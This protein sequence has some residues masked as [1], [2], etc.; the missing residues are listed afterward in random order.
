MKTRKIILFDGICNLCNQSVQFVIEHDDKNQFQFASLQS[1][2]GQNFLK[3]NNL[4]ATQFDSVVFIEDDK[5]YTKSSA[6]LKISKYL[7]GITSWLTIFMIVPKPLRDV[8][9]SFIAKNRYRWF[10]K[11]ESCWLP[12]PE[13]KA[14]FLD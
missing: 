6:A 7:D 12:T 4:D 1:D 8:V 10:G 9:Y 11:Q 2:F 14:K 5:F 3:E 13:L